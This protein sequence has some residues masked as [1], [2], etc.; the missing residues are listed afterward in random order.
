MNRQSL[1]LVLIVLSQFFCT[2]L[3]FATNAVS[4]EIAL[5][6]GI[7]NTVSALTSAVQFGFL[8]GTL[9]FAIFTIADRFSASRVFLV[10]A[11][12]GAF[13]N[14]AI[15][16]TYSW[17][18]MQ[19]ERFLTGFF[20]AGIYPVGMKIASDHFP[21]GLGVALGYLVGALVLGTAF[22]HLVRTGLQDF[23]WTYVV[24]VSTGL[25]LLGGLIIGF[26]VGDGPHRKGLQN[27]DFRAIVKV[28]RINQFRS[29]AIG[30][31]GHMWELYAFWTFMPI[32][33]RLHEDSQN[34]QSLLYFS[35]IG[36]GA[37]SC[38]AGGYVSKNKGSQFV[39]RGSLLISLVC[40]LLSPLALF[41][42]YGAFLIFL[43]CWGFFVIS[44]SPQF[45]TLVAI[46]APAEYRGTGLTIVNSIG[47]G[48]TILSIQLLQWMTIQTWSLVLLGIGP[49][50]GLW[51]FRRS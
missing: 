32:Y 27:F 2:T 30:Y 41:L 1:I 12:L 15:I 8:I 14:L 10:C 25:S 29:A 21:D 49:L 5:R 11:I 34:D 48:L 46:A 9:V 42:P 3:W 50:L 22:P 35:I 24:T 26:G 39:A 20:L 4:T 37:L 7:G 31:F 38:I 17:E 36:I 28:F 45:S 23:N 19:L 33:V 40:C 16:Y 47:F 6:L 18:L 13:S 44:D 43:L 51:F